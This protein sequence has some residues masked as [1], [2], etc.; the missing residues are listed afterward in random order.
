MISNSLRKYIHKEI[1][2]PDEVKQKITQTSLSLA[3]ADPSTWRKAESWKK[4]RFFL[5][6]F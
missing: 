1:R 5:V 4:K 2:L 6:H 3:E